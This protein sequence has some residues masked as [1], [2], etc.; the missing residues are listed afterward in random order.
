MQENINHELLDSMREGGATGLS[1]MQTRPKHENSSI[2]KIAP[3]WL[4]YDRQVSTLPSLRQRIPHAQFEFNLLYVMAK[5][6]PIF[7]N[8]PD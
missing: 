3:K 1:G 8:R 7:H 2:P 5:P 6:L 4:K